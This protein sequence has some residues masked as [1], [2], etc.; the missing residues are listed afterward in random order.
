MNGGSSPLRI[1]T[2]EVFP[3][4]R[5]VASPEQGVEPRTPWNLMSTTRLTPC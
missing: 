4:Y 5:I 2:Q 1:E 3:P